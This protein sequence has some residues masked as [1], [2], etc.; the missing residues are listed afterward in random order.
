MLIIKSKSNE[1][2]KNGVP[3]FVYIV[4][5]TEKDAKKSAA[6]IEEY[7]TSQ[8]EHARKNDKGEYLY[9][10]QRVIPANSQLTLTSKGR[11]QVLQENLEKVA[12]EKEAAIEMF[13]NQFLGKLKAV[14][15][16]PA[17]YKAQMMA[18]L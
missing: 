13:A 2:I 12:E 15:V 8:G 4:G 11:Y 18:S 10:S 14:G 3:I 9:F 1:Y 16:T 7:V 17:Q 6:E 5:S